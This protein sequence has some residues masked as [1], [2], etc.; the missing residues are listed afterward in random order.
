MIGFAEGMAKL[1]YGTE[2]TD[3]ITSIEAIPNSKP[4]IYTLDGTK[5]NQITGNGV[6]IIKSNGKT[7]KVVIKK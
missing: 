1:T 7:K 6:Y 4:S 5:I 2:I 3:G